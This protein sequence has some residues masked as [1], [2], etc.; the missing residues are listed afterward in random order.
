MFG[1]NPK[2][3]GTYHLQFTPPSTLTPPS[4]AHAPPSS[5]GCALTRVASLMA[6][7]GC[8]GLGVGAP[9]L[10]GGHPSLKPTYSQVWAL[11]CVPSRLGLGFWF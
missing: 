3:F 9:C 7:I 6:G 1:A 11:S 10:G 8:L 5:A 4:R 2:G